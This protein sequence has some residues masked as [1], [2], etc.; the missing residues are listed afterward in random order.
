[1]F[2]RTGIKPTPKDHARRRHCDSVG[3][4]IREIEVTALLGAREDGM[5][6]ELL[7]LAGAYAAVG[8]AMVLASAQGA[9]SAAW[10]ESLFG[11]AMERIHSIEPSALRYPV[12]VRAISAGLQTVSLARQIHYRPSGICAFLECCIFGVIVLTF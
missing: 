11:S 12:P 10:R 4:D 9:D 2:A 6:D 8:T 5:V 7:R 1:M 3:S